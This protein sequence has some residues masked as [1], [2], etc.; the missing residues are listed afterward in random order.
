MLRSGWEWGWWGVLMTGGELW[1]KNFCPEQW[2]TP[3]ERL[4]HNNILL[5]DIGIK[6][7]W[8]SWK[9]DLYFCWKDRLNFFACHRCFAS[10]VQPILDILSW[11]QY[12]ILILIMVRIILRKRRMMIIVMLSILKSIVCQLI[13]ITI[14]QQLWKA[15]IDQIEELQ[16]KTKFTF[17]HKK[18]HVPQNKCLECAFSRV[19]RKK[20]F[21]KTRTP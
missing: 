17:S 12:M 15:T 19:S 13:E 4:C 16:I 3:A 8:A 21:S 6:K 11:I 2:V 1:S 9:Y 7:Q 5:K 18:S 20:V 14:D 10:P